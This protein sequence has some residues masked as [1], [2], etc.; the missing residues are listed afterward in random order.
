MKITN[1]QVQATYP[2]AKRVGA[3]ELQLSFAVDE[4]VTSHGMN[5]GSAQGYVYVVQR[6]I[7]G[8]EYRRTINVYATD[9]FLE[10]IHRDFGI[11]GLALAVDAVR[12]H[13]EYYK[14]VGKSPQPAIGDLLHKYLV[15]VET[16]WTL[17]SYHHMF[18]QQ[19][20]R[21]LRDAAEDRQLRL[22]G[23]QR[24]PRHIHVT[25]KVY[26]RNPDVV[27]EVLER[28]N[29]LCEQCGKPAPFIRASDNSAYL[30]VHHQIQL[31]HDG[32]DTVENSVAL[33]PN[34]HRRFHYGKEG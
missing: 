26:L 24:K 3:G 25:A 28:A 16:G 1:A 18:T 20:D 11:T 8:R 14:G 6:L 10:S 2:L 17:E 9:Y 22:K 15:V 31:A 19:I 23:S 12:K 7:E 4:L 34:C 32:E 13:L 30:E 21:S 33:C 5:R 29:G 27:A